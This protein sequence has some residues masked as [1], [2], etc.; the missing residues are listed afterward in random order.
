MNDELRDSTFSQRE[1]KSPL[2][3]VMKL[4]HIPKKFRNL[5]WLLIGEE[6]A[7]SDSLTF[8]GRLFIE[9]VIWSYVFEIKEIPHDE[10]QS[11]LN[12]KYGKFAREILLSGDYHEAITLVEYIIRHEECSDE[13]KDSLIE[14]FDRSPVAY[15]VQEMNGKPTVIPRISREAGEATRQALETLDKGGMNGAT[16]HLRQ[17]AEHINA[18]QYADS[19]A[20][21][22]H[23]VE[24]V[25]RVIDPAASKTLG[26][27]LD[28]L[29]KAGVPIHKA[30]K[31]AFK[32]LYGYTRDEQGICHALLEKGAADVGQDEALFMFGACAS[33]A[34]YL[35]AKADGPANEKAGAR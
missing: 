34:A 29:E 11:V 24:S 23:A 27:A 26:P 10:V 21:S 28:S 16:T 13:L 17:A 14:A 30:L 2:P 25:A 7:K 8:S 35:T 15:F 18:Q 19:I 20:D 31:E 3:E 22:I 1:G 9:N 12:W 33:F 4:E 6:I 5:A 32:K